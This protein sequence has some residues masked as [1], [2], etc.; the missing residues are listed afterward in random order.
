MKRSVQSLGLVAVIALSACGAGGGD[1]S[2]TQ[3]PFGQIRLLVATEE[4]SEPINTNSAF[5]IETWIDAAR[6][7]DLSFQAIGLPGIE[8]GQYQITLGQLSEGSSF[9]TKIYLD[10]DHA[11]IFLGELTN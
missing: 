10:G 5:R 7:P 3:H 8:D 6:Q 4:L 9:R 11:S 2:A 1:S